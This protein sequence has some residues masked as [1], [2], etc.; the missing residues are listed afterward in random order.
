MLDLVEVR[1]FRGND[2]THD[3]I[4]HLDH[5]HIQTEL[6][7][8]RGGFEP[9]IAGANDDQASSDV[10]LGT[11]LLD[12]IDTP[13]V[14]HAP[15]VATL[16]RQCPC[17]RAQRQD[18]FVVANVLAILDLQRLVVTIDSRNCRFQSYL[19][20]MVVVEVV[21]FQVEALG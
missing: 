9:D 7:R 4:S 8:H 6:A 18:E 10:H 14:V 17:A 15:E 13:Q 20:L 16:D 2:A 21:S 12:V 11:N 19:D 1:Y 3:A 5:G